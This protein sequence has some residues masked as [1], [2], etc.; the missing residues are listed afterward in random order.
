MKQRTLQTEW[1]DDFEVQGAE[2]DATLNDIS[3][4]NRWLGGN[5]WTSKALFQLWKEDANSPK[6]LCDVG[7][8][9]G[10][11]LAY[12]A[13]KCM[14][15]GIPYAFTGVD[16]NPHTIAIAKERHK[17]IP[18]LHFECRDIFDAHLP[19]HNIDYLCC[20]LTLHHFENEKVEQ[21]LTLWSKKIRKGFV[22]NDLHRSNIAIPLFKAVAFVFHLHPL[23]VSDGLTSIQKGFRKNELESWMKH[24]S[25]AKYNIKWRWAFRFIVTFKQNH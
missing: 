11:Y 19:W 7:C 18:N 17:N 8:G 23:S 20:N 24:V 25:H 16:A 13:K 6:Q 12:L 21:L 10:D 14:Q 22:I 1:M 5:Q 9:N 4:I 3:K 15:M 2:L